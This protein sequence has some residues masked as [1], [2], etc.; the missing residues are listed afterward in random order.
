[1]CEPAVVAV[2]R[3]FE[4]RPTAPPPSESSTAAPSPMSFV[5]TLDQNSTPSSRMPRNRVG[6][7]SGLGARNATQKAQLGGIVRRSGP[8]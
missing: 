2:R 6:G 1:M 8:V 4:S 7:G 5:Q 3:S